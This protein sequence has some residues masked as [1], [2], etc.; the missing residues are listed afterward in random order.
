MVR[1][2]NRCQCRAVGSDIFH[3]LLRDKD[4]VNPGHQCVVHCVGNES[5]VHFLGV[6]VLVS[7]R[8][9]SSVDDTELIKERSA[10]LMHHISLRG[11]SCPVLDAVLDGVKISDYNLVG[12]YWELG[13]KFLWG[14]S[15]LSVLGEASIGFGGRIDLDKPEWCCWYRCH[16][17]YLLKGLFP[18]DIPVCC[19]L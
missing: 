7:G 17:Q 14:F 2:S 16:R 3:Q 8:R 18:T 5:K 4:V 9:R 6:V 1:H 12:V 15:D 10:T 19:K 13:D 11:D